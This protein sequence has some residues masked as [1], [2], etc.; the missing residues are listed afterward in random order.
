MM[1][2]W[3]MGA[4]GYTVTTSSADITLLESGEM[5]TVTVQVPYDNVELLGM[6]LFP[7]PAIL[8]GSA[9]MAK[10]GP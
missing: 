4:S 2:A 6:S 5:V 8:R 10:E 1:T 9:T 3:G 7:V